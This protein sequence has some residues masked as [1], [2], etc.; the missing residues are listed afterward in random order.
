M[1]FP[2]TA[3]IAVFL[4][5]WL[6]PGAA[7]SDIVNFAY[8]VSSATV[9]TILSLANTE[10]E[11]LIDGM[12]T[13]H[14]SYFYKAGANA[15]DNDAACEE[16]DFTWTASPNDLV[17][18]SPDEY[19]G[20]GS[21]GILFNDAAF[22]ATYDPPSVSLALLRGITRPMRFTAYVDN[23][24]GVVADDDTLTAARATV[25]ETLSGAAWGYRGYNPRGNS[26]DGTDGGDGKA[27]G[28]F[29]EPFEVFGEV[30]GPGDGPN[31]NGRGEDGV[32]VSIKPFDEFVSV[33]FVQPVSHLGNTDSKGRKVRAN[34]HRGNLE[35]IVTISVS[36]YTGRAGDAMFD[37]D[38]NPVSANLEAAVTC[39]GALR[40]QDL[41]S[42]GAALLLKDAGGW[43]EFKTVPMKRASGRRRGKRGTRASPG[44][45]RTDE[46][47][48]HFLEHND[49]DGDGSGGTVD[50]ESVGGVINNGFALRED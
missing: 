19:F 21:R 18:V 23:N 28:G 33:F 20:S 8:G 44:R 36:D 27:R 1:N 9:T 5:A 34:Q 2:R 38:G 48:T 12:E 14:F 37:R 47:V 42:D 3:A 24:D 49:P 50:G 35:S 6:A 32:D 25:I 10:V 22:W 4:S 26:H 46:V 16:V 41:L 15:T 31:P 45:I 13:L 7:R 17:S 39:V 43:G 40:V 30:V 11:P 29:S